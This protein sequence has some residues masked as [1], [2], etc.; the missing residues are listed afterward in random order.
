MDP[1]SMVG[2]NAAEV[3]A[4]LP[5]DW[6]VYP[7]PDGRPGFAAVDPGPLPGQYGSVGMHL[8]GNPHMR[9]LTADAPVPIYLLNEC[10]ELRTFGS[11][12]HGRSTA[13]D[14]SY[15]V[16]LAQE[17]AYAAMLLEANGLVR[18][19]ETDLVTGDSKLLNSSQGREA[20]SWSGNWRRE[21]GDP[22]TRVVYSLDFTKRGRRLMIS[23]KTIRLK[24]SKLRNKGRG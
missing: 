16:E 13:P 20:M 17:T 9:M 10:W 11:L 23:R 22:P 19:W 12:V 4:A 5:E 21:D 18:I 8:A 2:A 14:G 3:M 24:Y 15:S 7:F 6:I 1:E